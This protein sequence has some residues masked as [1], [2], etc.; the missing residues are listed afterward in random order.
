MWVAVCAVGVVL[1]PVLVGFAPLDGDPELMYQPIKAELGRA[2]RSGRLPFWSNRFGLGVPLIAESHVAAFYPLNWF[3]YGVCG[4]TTGYCLSLWLHSVGLVLATFMYARGLGIEPTGCGLAAVCFALCGFQAVHLVH[5]PFYH[6][7]PFLPLCLYLGDRYAL[8]GRWSWLA[9]LALAWGTQLTLGHFQIQMWT[10][11]LVLITGSWLALGSTKGSRQQIGRICGLVIGLGWGAAI[12]WVQLGLTWELTRIAGFVRPPEFLSNYLFPPAHWAQFALPAVFLGRPLG[13][14]D[15]Y[16]G[17]QGTTPG[18]ACAYVGVVALLLAFVGMVASSRGRVLAIWRLIIPLTLL[19]AT[20]PGWWPDGFYA[21]SKVP[22]FGWFRAP[23]RYTLLPSLGLALLAGRGLDAAVPARRFWPGLILAV[24]VGV[25][26]W[27]WSIW[28]AQRAD[29]QAGLGADTVFVRFAVT[30]LAWGMGIA[31]VIGWRTKQLHTGAVFGL[32]LVEL[33]GLLFAGPVLWHW[34]I[35]LP[36]ASAVLQKLAGSA[37][38]GLVAGRLLNVPVDGSQ[39]AAFPNL[40]IVPPPPNYLLEPTALP[41]G[42]NTEFQRRWQRRF[43]VTHG[44]W[45]SRDDVRGTEVLAEIPDPALDRVMGGVPVLRRGG[46]GPWKLVRV[47]NPFPPVWIARRIREAAGWGQL[48]TELSRSDVPDQAWFLSEDG[49]PTLPSPLDRGGQIQGWDGET[50]TVKHDGSCILIVR[51]THYP[52]W[53]Y[54]VNGGPAQPVLK[55]NGGLQGAPIPGSGTSRITMHYQP[56]GLRQAVLVSGAAVGCAVLV[57]GA[58]GCGHFRRR[59]RQIS[60]E[61][62]GVR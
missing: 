7:M 2:L 60:N 27:A 49:S 12:A 24:V 5:E 1:S 35:H 45:G 22:G 25:L 62:H 37:D 57:L 13:A 30:G 3:F 51:R 26:A 8:T 59:A 39:T 23:A 40:G 61:L 32:V 48:Y 46:L 44:V 54:R 10:G 14:G 56:T 17:R 52:G 36:E 53:V 11:G 9:G 50:A 47:P 19:L 20:M 34:T 4:V 31:A 41:P 18:E 28:W 42:E 6:L 38:V 21:L 33:G 43:G 29:F 58:A 15:T 55:V 16:W